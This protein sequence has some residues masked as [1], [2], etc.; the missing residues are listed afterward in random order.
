MPAVQNWLDRHSKTGY[1]ANASTMADIC[2]ALGNAAGFNRSA[3]ADVARLAI[4][5]S[6]R[7]E[8]AGVVRLARR[9]AGLSLNP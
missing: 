5:G 1:Q 3:P 9:V 2:R 4:P 8:I 7:I 6:T